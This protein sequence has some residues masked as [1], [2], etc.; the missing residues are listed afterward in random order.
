MRIP[1]FALL[2]RQLSPD[3]AKILKLIP[4]GPYTMTFKRTL[5]EEGEFFGEP[6]IESDQFPSACLDYPGNLNFYMDHL[7]ALGLAGLLQIG[8]QEPLYA[9]QQMPGERKRQVAVRVRSE[10]RLSESG[11]EVPESVHA[12]A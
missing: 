8:L 9:V 3:E 1:A 10:Y 2:I 4:E 11:K 5:T 12:R 6:D 7:Q